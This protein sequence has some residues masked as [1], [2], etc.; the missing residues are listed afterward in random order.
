M[1]NRFPYKAPTPTEEDTN[2]GNVV[3]ILVYMFPRQFG[4]HNP[5]TSVVDRQ[6]TTQKFQD[7]TLR[8]EE[9]AEKFSKLDTHGKPIRHVPKRLRGQVQH[10][11]E[12]L[13]ILHGRCAYAEMMKHYC[14]VG[15]PV[16]I[17]LVPTLTLLGTWL[18]RK[19]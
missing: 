4:L 8:E 3:H 16:P 17:Q 10:L 19:P 1:L 14:P 12:R 13:Q 7:Y 2:H 15:C 11:V 9:I 18:D 5:F 6:K